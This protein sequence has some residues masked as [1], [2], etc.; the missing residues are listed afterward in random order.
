VTPSNDLPT[1][2]PISNLTIPEDSG[3]RTIN[4]SGIS[5]GPLETQPL[6]ITAT[7]SNTLVIPVPTVTYTSPNA[8]GT[9]TF[10]P[11][12]NAFGVSTITVTVEDG[13]IDG[14]LATAADNGV[15]TRSFVVTVTSVNDVPVAASGNYLVDEGD[16]FT[17][18]AGPS[19]DVD[20]PTGDILTYSWD[21]NGDG[22]YDINSGTATTAVVTWAQLTQFG[23]TAPSV[24][25]I[26]LR[27]TDA[28]NASSTVLVQLSTLIVD[29]G[30]APNTYGTLKANNGAA[31]TINGV[32][33]LGSSIDKEA[34][35][36]PSTTATGD[37][38]DEDGVTLTSTIE[39]S[40]TLDLPSL[41]TVV[42]SAAGKLDP[43]LI[44]TTTESS[45]PVNT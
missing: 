38:A 14:N 8:T 18:N 40:P 13:G 12:A 7:S 39:A 22:T 3:V 29:Y 37:G 9:L 26:R 36:Q 42:S 4:L 6:R 17:L 27:V 34:N 25:Q 21:L 35:G 19:F 2:N 45:N 41:M 23:V 44:S 16:G 32:L 24:R 1:V 31:H 33:F 15:T 10:T 28:S 43:G 20:E 30:D 11:A 5:A